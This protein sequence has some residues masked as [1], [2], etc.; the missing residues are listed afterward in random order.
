[1]FTQPAE[2]GEAIMGALRKYQ[3]EHSSVALERSTKIPTQPDYDD[4][5]TDEQLEALRRQVKPAID[6]DEWEIVDGPAW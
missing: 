2:R 5:V 4:E 1:M 3:T 6:A